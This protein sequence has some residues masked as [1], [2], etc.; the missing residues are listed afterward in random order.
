ML[1][2]VIGMEDNR[3]SSA[4]CKISHVNFFFIR[5]VKFFFKHI[6]ALFLLLMVKVFPNRY[7]DKRLLVIYDTHTQP[8]SVGD[9][10]LFMA[11]SVVL[12]KI[13]GIKD[14]DFA[15]IYDPVNPEKV[16][17]VFVGVVNSENIFS[18]LGKVLFV[19]EMCKHISSIFIFN[20]HNQFQKYLIDN[21][22]SYDIW[23]SQIHIQKKNY[24]SPRVFNELLWEYFKKNADIPEIKC[25]LHLRLWA[26]KF[27]NLHCKNHIP[28][29][30]N[31]RFNTDWHQERNANIK[32]WV[33]F[34]KYCEERYPVTF[35]LISAKN[36]YNSIF[37]QCNNI[38]YAKD[39]NT[40]LDQDLALMA[41][42]KMHMGSS[43]GPATLAWF[44][45][46]PYLI[47]K[48]RSN[49][50]DNFFDKSI[51]ISKFGS[52]EK[53]WFANDSQLFLINSENTSNLINNFEIIWSKEFANDVKK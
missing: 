12:S 47:F 32:S 48:P 28:I 31:L 13:T 40:S 51:M 49:L 35:I 24:Q 21:A 1:K 39:S 52:A 26:E 16:D 9:A 25:R 29:T 34:F 4:M 3:E 18:H 5:K 53:F 27:I 10:I 8:F 50:L 11:A 41:S 42:C 15:L 45:N 38:V 2:G 7:E 44:S 14:V 46:K 19:A 30:V 43:S 37:Q 33:E 23:P 17:P 6:A 36:E 22:E 20:S